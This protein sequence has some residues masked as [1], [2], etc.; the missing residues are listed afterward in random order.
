MPGLRSLGRASWVTLPRSRGV[1]LAR[2]CDSGMVWLDQVAVGSLVSG[3][4]RRW[5]G[6]GWGEWFVVYRVK[7][8]KISVNLEQR[9]KS[10]EFETE[11]IKLSSGGGGSAVELAEDV[12]RSDEADEAKAHDEHNGFFSAS[13]DLF[14]ILWPSS[15]AGYSTSKLK[16]SLATSST[17]RKEQKVDVN[18][19]DSTYSAEWDNHGWFYMLVRVALFLWVWN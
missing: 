4:M 16:G 18:P 13:L 12:E 1:G 19:A 8:S 15:L 9:S 3:L 10:S 6:V 11:S 17:S 7:E 2:W 5:G 14:F